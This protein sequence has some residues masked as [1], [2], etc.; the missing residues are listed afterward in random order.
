MKEAAEAAGLP[1]HIISWIE[2]PSLDLSALLMKEVDLILATG[3]E[4]MGRAAYSSRY[5]RWPR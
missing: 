4:G 2:E 1:K 3:G 5:R